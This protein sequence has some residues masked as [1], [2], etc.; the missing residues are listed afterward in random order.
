MLIK[1]N[2]DEDSITMI[3]ENS[4]ELISKYSNLFKLLV[5]SKYIDKD[6]IILNKTK[7]KGSMKEL[8]LLL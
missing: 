6:Y 7:D 2:I 3:V 8:L 5:K 4:K 1:L